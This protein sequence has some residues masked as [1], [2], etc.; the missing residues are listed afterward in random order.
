MQRKQFNLLTTTRGNATLI[1]TGSF[2]SSRI[3][4][5]WIVFKSVPQTIQRRYVFK[6]DMKW[7][8]EVRPLY[9]SSTVDVWLSTCP[10][11]P[12]LL[13]YAHQ[14]KQTVYMRLLLL[15]KKQ[16]LM[17]H[18]KQWLTVNAS[19]VAQTLNIH[20]STLMSNSVDMTCFTYQRKKRVMEHVQFCIDPH[21]H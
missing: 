10:G 6:H 1:V 11:I 17:I 4:H 9:L 18:G 14:T 15:W 8:M 20:M 5:S 16:P 3:T 7:D 2:S 21:L 12:R 13:Q 19:L